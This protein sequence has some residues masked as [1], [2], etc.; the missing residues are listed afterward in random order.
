MSINRCDLCYELIVDACQD[1]YALITGLDPNET[2]TMS[3][4]TTNGNTITMTGSLNQDNE[5]TIPTASFPQGMF[6]AY[7]G[8]YEIVFTLDDEV[9]E[10][11][12]DGNSYYCILMKFKDVTVV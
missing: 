3:L 4:E 12:I 1:S 8:D 6:N 2:Y 11:T 10:L 9:Q 7:S 5:F